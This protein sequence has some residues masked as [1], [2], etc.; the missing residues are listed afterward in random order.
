M[1]QAPSAGAPE[2][3]VDGADV[4]GDQQGKA[5]RK[6]EGDEGIPHRGGLC[7]ALGRASRRRRGGVGG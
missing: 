4:A 3:A 5:Q 2:Q 7:F 6:A 1:T